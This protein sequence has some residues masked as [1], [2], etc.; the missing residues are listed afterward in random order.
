MKK[1]LTLTS[2]LAISFC[3]S[4]GKL[5][6]ENYSNYDLQMRVIAGNPNNCIPEVGASMNFPA[7]TQ[8]VI[9]NFNDSQPYTTHWSAILTAGGN[10]YQEYAPN[11]GLLNTVSPLTRWKFLWYQ[12]VYPGTTNVAYDTVNFNMGEPSAFPN[13]PLQSSPFV[14]GTLTDAFWFYIP[15]ENAT[16]LVIQ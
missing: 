16:Y 10:T 4:Q 13:C 8:D 3:F 14:D 9:E 11:S 15:S 2:L 5:Y 1:I 7:S 6:I 12:T